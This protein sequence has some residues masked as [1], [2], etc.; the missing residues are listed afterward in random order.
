MGRIET[1]QSCSV[2]SSLNVFQRQRLT[3]EGESRPISALHYVLHSVFSWFEHLIMSEKAKQSETLSQTAARYPRLQSTVISSCLLC[4][5]HSY[6]C[7]DPNLSGRSSHRNGSCT[8]Y[9]TWA[10]RRTDG[11]GRN[12]CMGQRDV[13]YGTHT[14]IATAIAECRSLRGG[15][16]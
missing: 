6:Q 1:D 14:G 5:P 15:R 12:G 3:E 8:L 16:K 10:G 2:L 4:C 9:V 13:V 7:S 11:R